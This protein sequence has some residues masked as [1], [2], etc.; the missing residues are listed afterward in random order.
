MSP[1]SPDEFYTE[2]KKIAE[3]KDEKY[4]GLNCELTH[5]FMDK[6]MCKVLREL[7]YESGV[8][9]FEKTDKWYS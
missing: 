2:M 6:L 9:I 1:T 7:G 5:I 8:E 4:P 3:H